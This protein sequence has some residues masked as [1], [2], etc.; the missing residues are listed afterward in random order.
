MQSILPP[1]PRFSI[2]FGHRTRPQ[3]RANCCCS[4][5]SNEAPSSPLLR[6]PTEKNIITITHH[7]YWL[8][9]L[10]GVRMIWQSKLVRVLQ[11]IRRWSSLFNYRTK[12]MKYSKLVEQI[13]IEIFSVSRSNR[14][15]YYYYTIFDLAL[16][17]IKY[18]I[19][20]FKW[21]HGILMSWR[22]LYYLYNF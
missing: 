2:H 7:W 22:M 19:I 16:F 12:N 11:M 4:R 8:S 1:T 17:L 9:P 10:Q 6:A 15:L 18:T 5:Q 13:W 14:K 21:Y 3:C 20:I